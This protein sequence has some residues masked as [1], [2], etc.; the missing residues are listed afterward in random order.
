[1]DKPTPSWQ[2]CMSRVPW[3]A[4]SLQDQRLVISFRHNSLSCLREHLD[5]RMCSRSVVLVLDACRGDPSTAHVL[6]DG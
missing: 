1:M 6:G 2:S 5:A 4:A 3:A